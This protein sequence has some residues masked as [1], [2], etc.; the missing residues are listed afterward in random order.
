MT[1]ALAAARGTGKSN[2][3]GV[4]YK[5]KWTS[6]CAVRHEDQSTL[7]IVGAAQVR[8]DGAA[9]ELGDIEL[10]GSRTLS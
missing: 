5:G 10:Q 2:R 6:N 7:A 9:S 4:D 8:V 3:S 1:S